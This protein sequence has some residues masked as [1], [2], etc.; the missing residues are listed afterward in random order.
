MINRDQ[1]LSD[2]MQCICDNCAECSQSGMHCM[3]DLI[4]DMFN[5]LEWQDAVTPK[6]FMNGLIKQYKCGYCGKHLVNATYARDNYCSK[7]GKAVRWNGL[8]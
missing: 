3:E 8:N 2:A 7:C 6:V 1:I 4:T 5:L